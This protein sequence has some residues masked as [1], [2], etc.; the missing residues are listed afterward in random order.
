MEKGLRKGRRKLRG[1]LT[2]EKVKLKLVFRK[3]KGKKETA[4]HSKKTRSFERGE[5][6]SMVETS[7]HGR[8]WQ[9]VSM[10]R[11]VGVEWRRACWVRRRGLDHLEDGEPKEVIQQGSVRSRSDLGF[12]KRIA[13]V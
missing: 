13:T 9:G 7:V 2:K 5:K 12:A 3:E 10:G 8:T 4:R 1:G 11:Q 6:E